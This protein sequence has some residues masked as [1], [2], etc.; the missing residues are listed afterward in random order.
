MELISAPVTVDRWDDLVELFGDRGATRGCWCMARRLSTAELASNGNSGNRRALRAL[1][2]A[3]EPIGLLGYRENRPV[4]WCAV[5]PRSAYRAIVSSRTLPIDDPGVPVW[6]I[7]CFYIAA[8]Y[9]RRGLMAPLIEAALA[10]AAAG[11]AG[12]VEA[13]PVS[14]PPGD[15][16]RGLLGTFLD[17]G[18][19]VYAPDRTTSRRH[20]VVRRMP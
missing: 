8:G 11:G 2:E 10:Y 5:A 9:R 17:A 4:A 15:F 20:V 6:A 12:L 7:N 16:S 18:F 13:Y 1:V 19:S 14:E 3:G